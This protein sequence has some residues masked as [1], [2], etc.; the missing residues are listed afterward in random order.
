MIEA[1]DV[2]RFLSSKEE[3]LLTYLGEEVGADQIAKSD[4]KVV[5]SDLRAIVAL[6]PNCF[7]VQEPTLE[8]IRK[9]IEGGWYCLCNVNQ[10]ILQA[11]DGY[12]GHMLF[13]YGVSSRGLRIHNPGPPATRATEIPWKVFDKAWSYPTASVRN[14]LAVH[15]RKET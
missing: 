14:I 8:D 6:K 10:R 11:D 9:Y 3:Y 15:G 4:L 12:V 5:E 13:V 1:F 7:L 2:N